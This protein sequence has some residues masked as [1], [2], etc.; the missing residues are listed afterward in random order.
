MGLT[1][2]HAEELQQ[3]LPAIAQTGEAMLGVQNTYRQRYIID[4]A[5][6]TAVGTA[7]VRS[8]WIVLVGQDVPHLT[9]C[10]IL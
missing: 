1:T 6:T 7:V 5:M 9:S 8:T 10:Y 4:S 2:A 3:Y